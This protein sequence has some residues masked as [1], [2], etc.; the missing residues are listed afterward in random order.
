MCATRTRKNPAKSGAVSPLLSA[1]V[2]SA[3]VHLPKAAALHAA[4]EAASNSSKGVWQGFMDVVAAC[5]SLAELH[6][7]IGN[8]KNNKAKDFEAGQIVE[9]IKLGA[10]AH[11]LN[12]DDT[13][14]VSDSLKSQ[15]SKARTIGHAVLEKGYV[16]DKALGRDKQVEAAKLA[17]DGGTAK[18][19]ET[20]PKA[21][22]SKTDTIG[23]LIAKFG[24]AAVL[25]ECAAVLGSTRATATQAAAV[26]A[27][28][29]QIKS[30]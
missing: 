8:G 17:L 16:I 23:Q 1:V 14:K 25:Q 6:A 2:E 18:A 11:K 26:A 19:K 15:A 24:L 7:L 3:I 21:G 13:K 9:A 10:A 27:V 22:E 4:F 29:S 12:D 5:K 30:A 28:A 20:T